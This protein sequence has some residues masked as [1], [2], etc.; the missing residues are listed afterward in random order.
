MDRLI[1]DVLQT[2]GELEIVCPSDPVSSE[3]LPFSTGGKDSLTLPVMADRD[4]FTLFNTWAL[5]LK[6][7][8]TPINS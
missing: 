7:F 6:K 4:L 3:V 2:S 1:P 8:R 5:K